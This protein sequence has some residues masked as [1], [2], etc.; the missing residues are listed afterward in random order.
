MVKKESGGWRMC[1]DLT[2]LNVACPK[3]SYL[4][5]SIDSLIDKSFM[6]AYSGYN[7]LKIRKMRK[8]LLSLPN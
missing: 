6:D 1:T 5:P 2:N 3:D 4:L 8:K 7:Q